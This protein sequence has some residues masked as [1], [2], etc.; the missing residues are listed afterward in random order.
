MNERA[1]SGGALAVLRWLLLLAGLLLA[2]CAPAAGP[3]PAHLVQA[4]FWA[5]PSSDWAPP[6]SLPAASDGV[7]AARTPWATVAL[8]HARA[9]QAATDPRGA[10]P[11][12]EVVWYRVQ[13]PAAALTPTP[14]GPRL[15]IPRWQTV[16]TVAV[17]V[18]DDLVWQTH[19]SRVWNSFNHPV[20]IDLGG[21]LP[22]PGQ[23]LSVHVRMASLPGV[24]GALSTLWAGP[25]E[26]LQPGWRARTVLQ[27]TL[28]GFM[29]GSYL[30]LGVFALGLWAARRRHGESIY[31]WFFLMAV[32]QMLNTLPYLVDEQG[33]IELPDPWF[34]W[35]T[36]VVGTLGSALAS[37]YFL[38]TINALRWRRLE[39]AL[40][41]YVAL[42]AAL[43]F[44]P[45]GL[46]LDRVLPLLR[47]ALVPTALAVAAAALW[48][49]WL[50]RTPASLLLAAWIV[51]SFPLGFHD[52]ALQSYRIDIEHIYF[53]P[54]IYV[55][56]F[57]MFLVIAHARYLR[58][59]GVAERANDT[60]A[61]RL[62][63]Q[64]QALDET[65]AR[66]RAAERAQTLLHE[67]Q[68]LMREMHDGVGS[69]LMSALRWVEHGGPGAV[70]VAQ[71]L[72]ESIDDL[73]IS[74]DSLE[75]VDADLLALLASLR[76]RLGPRLE[77]AG[78]ALHWQ[79][80]DLP[81]LPWLDAQNALHVL[82]IV[83]EVL[84][85]IVKHS[86][87]RTITLRTAPAARGGVA[88]VQVQVQDDGR[89]FTPPAPEARQPGR[90]GLGNVQ[91]RA[92]A[93]GAHVDWAPQAGGGT[94]FTLWLPLQGPGEVP[95]GGW[96]K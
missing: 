69:S 3:P 74:I 95:S 84:T 42:V 13:L 77:G 58:A 18:D 65:H 76:Y 34:A 14:Q 56:L 5:S 53:T 40:V 20:W 16:G 30:I 2:G 82:R 27:T 54:Y 12:P 32:F 35:L 78:L 88:G 47:L 10:T 45:L 60:L 48:G 63:A 8:P 68:R 1:P 15:Y 86:G 44:P 6:P 46:H 72:R 75:P 43:T 29:R 37:F 66:L 87:A 25:A 85:N 91:A 36:H 31:A 26:A 81:P 49:A 96:V 64:Q 55:G 83:Q 19:G 17:Y 73:K 52:L 62:A 22:P 7:N 92:Q 23:P 28:V 39:Q 67:R 41:L 79:V 70:D 90:K 33:M 80:Q 21:L 24:G 93:L 38:R 59:L 89:P 57:T 9:R 51:L 50:R 94:V 71:V 61:E 4:E 11:P